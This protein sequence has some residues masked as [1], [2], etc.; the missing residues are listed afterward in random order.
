MYIIPIREWLHGR[1][2]FPSVIPNIIIIIIIVIY[3]LPGYHLPVCRTH[4]DTIKFIIVIILYRRNH[5]R[6][7]QVQRMLLSYDFV[8]SL[9][10]LIGV[11]DNI[12]GFLTN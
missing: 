8:P 12:I 1:R 9:L 2:W 11:L 7:A 5:N 3:I 10:Q 6:R 4:I